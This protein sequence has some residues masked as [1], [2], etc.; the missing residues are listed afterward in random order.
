MTTMAIAIALLSLLVMVG[1]ENMLLGLS[2]LLLNLGIWTGNL[3]LLV[4]NMKARYF[5]D[6]WQVYRRDVERAGK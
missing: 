6:R 4:H 1:L 2:S 3:A 5:V